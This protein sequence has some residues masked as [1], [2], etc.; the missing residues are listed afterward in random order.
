MSILKKRVKR[1]P[2]TAPFGVNRRNYK[3]AQSMFLPQRAHTKDMSGTSEE[4]RVRARAL[5]AEL[6]EALG[7]RPTGR[8][9]RAE[10][11]RRREADRASS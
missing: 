7:R 5:R 2:Q 11:K 8:E 9:Y 4:G 3:A 6:R 1:F 10:K